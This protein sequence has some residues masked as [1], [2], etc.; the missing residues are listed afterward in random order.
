MGAPY[1]DVHLDWP[2][3]TIPGSG[4]IRVT[5]SGDV[6]LATGRVL[7]IQRVSRGLLTNRREVDEHGNVL[8]G[9]YYYDT[10]YGASLLREYGDSVGDSDLDKIG[11]RIHDAYTATPEVASNPPPTARPEIMPNGISLALNWSDA[12]SGDPIAVGLV[13]PS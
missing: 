6:A 10:D 8:P 2:C 11:S 4:R 7:S 5:A 3:D 1:Y 13:L 9:D 12:Q